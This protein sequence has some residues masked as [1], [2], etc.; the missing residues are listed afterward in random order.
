MC[1]VSYTSGES[2]G[3]KDTVYLKLFNIGIE[4]KIVSN[5]LMFWCPIQTC[6]KL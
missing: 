3:L 2:Y 1:K 5:I 4:D 6:K